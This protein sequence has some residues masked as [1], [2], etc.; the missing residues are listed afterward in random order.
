MSQEVTPDDIIRLAGFA[1]KLA[2]VTRLQRSD[3][4]DIHAELILR[5]L[6]SQRSYNGSFKFST[7][8]LSFAVKMA[9]TLASSVRH[10][11]DA[12]TFIS[13]LALGEEVRPINGGEFLGFDAVDQADDGDMVATCVDEIIGERNADILAAIYIHGH[14]LRATA[15]RFGISPERV[16]QICLSCVRKIQKRITA[17]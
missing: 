17:S 2:K 9:S 13:E 3:R 6:K 4:D 10:R 15:D 1:M 8:Y 11:R 5:A 7:Y 16:R 12:T 14:T